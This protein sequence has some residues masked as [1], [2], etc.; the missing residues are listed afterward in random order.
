MKEIAG[1][2]LCSFFAVLLIQVILCSHSIFYNVHCFQAL[3]NSHVF[4]CVL[5]GVLAK[6]LHSHTDC[7][8]L[9][10]PHFVFSYVSSN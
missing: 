10:L 8:C 2:K 4:S 1:K 6:W 7:I 5:S 9:A 3:I